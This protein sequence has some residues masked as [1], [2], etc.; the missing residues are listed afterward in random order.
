MLKTLLIGSNYIC[1]KNIQSY[2]RENKI[3]SKILFKNIDMDVKEIF[4][5]IYK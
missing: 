4:K 5:K 1:L 2:C 3:K